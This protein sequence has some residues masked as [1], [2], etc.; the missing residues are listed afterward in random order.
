MISV[1]F[2]DDCDAIPATLWESCYAPPRE[3]VWWYRALQNCGIAS[4]FTF[5]YGLIEVT[6]SAGERRPVGIAP[7][8]LADVPME[9]VVPEEV[10]FLLN[11]PLKWFPS[12]GYQRTLF[13]GSPCADEGWVGIQ[14]GIDRR[15]ALLAVYDAVLAEAKRRRAPMLVWKDVPAVEKANMTWLQE[16]RKLFVLPSYPNTLVSFGSKS[17]DDY[18]AALKGSRRHQLKKKLRFS[19]NLVQLTVETI[20]APAPNVLDEIFGLFMQTFERSPIKF[21][22]LNRRTF[23]LLAAE[24]PVHF[25][26]LREPSGGL[27]AFM[28]C[29]AVGDLVINKYIGFDYGQPKEWMLYFRL[30]EAALD[31]SLERGA[32]GIQSGQT[33]YQPKI[34]QG[35]E[36]KPLFNYGRHLNPLMHWIY[37]KVAATITWQSLDEDLAT[38]LKAHPEADVGRP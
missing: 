33:C 3:G 1:R 28:M 14:D 24:P 23:E 11:L 5:I 16:Q 7:C 18:F 17:K 6:E 29:F 21:E 4:Q 32:S 31:W 9:L 26:L 36:L 12:L 2:L 38:Y 30:W 13:V 34:E 35:H 15:A 20:Q 10:M 8:F 19:K 25:I 27:I 22:R 37:R